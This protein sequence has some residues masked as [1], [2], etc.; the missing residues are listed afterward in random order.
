MDSLMV[1]KKPLKKIHFSKSLKPNKLSILPQYCSTISEIQED[2]FP[3]FCERQFACEHKI[4]FVKLYF[5]ACVNNEKS[6]KCHC[7]EGGDT[8]PPTPMVTTHLVMEMEYG[9]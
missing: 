1:L 8:S 3:E 5:D 4:S 2:P 7:N 9:Q 6:K